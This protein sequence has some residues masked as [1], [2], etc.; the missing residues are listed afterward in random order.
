VGEVT[1]EAA[2]A[3]LGTPANVLARHKVPVVRR[4]ALCPF[5]E[6][7]SRSL[8]LFTSKDGKQRWK[9]HAGCGSGDA[10]DLEAMFRGITVRQLLA[11]L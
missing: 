5:H 1:I 2:L 10:I 6:D 11:E 9:C 3:S 7:H 4:M 8:S